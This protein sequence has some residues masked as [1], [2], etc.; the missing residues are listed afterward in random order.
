MAET[1]NL[2]NL[3]PRPSSTEIDARSISTAPAT[4]SR[5]VSSFTTDNEQQY[6]PVD[7]LPPVDGGRR[8][9]LFLIGATSIEILVWGLPFSIGILHNY[10]TNTLFK[11]YGEGT[12]TL[13]A[14][15]QTGLLYMI[16]GLFGPVITALPRWQKTMQVFGL[17]AAS[18]SMIASAFAT[19]P[20]H[21]VITIGC[22]YPL[23]GACYLPCATLLFEWFH[24]RRG[25]ASGIMYAGTGVGGTIFPFVMS[26]LINGVGYKAA[27]I[28]I[29][30]GYLILGSIALIPI[31]RRIPLS[32]YDQSSS[33]AAGG[34]R[35]RQKIDWSFMK[36]HAMLMGTLTIL[37]TSLGNFIPSLWLP[38]YADELHLSNP[39]GTALIALMNAAS[40][41][42]NALLGYLSD[43]LPLYAV[44]V[45]SC[46]G[47]AASCAFLWG[48]GKHEAELVVFVIIFGGLGLSFSALWSKIISII[49]R[50]DPVAPA[51]VFSM[52]TFVRGVGNISSGPVSD[53]LLKIS[54]LKGVTGGYGVHNYGVLLIYT[55]VTILSGGAAGLML[56]GR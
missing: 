49:S 11:G 35:R 38:S 43:R 5:P 33:G 7:V 52:F 47:S 56:R 28:S 44:V 34:V 29:G 55:A 41:P 48:F 40:V 13:A 16:A 31:Q 20:W 45:V 10:W 36:R 2:P 1:I 24:G 22:F 14:T 27:M 8:A 15:L 53:A 25:M 32:R 50:D 9:W 17:V 42:G 23:S 37:M 54:S 6:N 12:I 30:I 4:D 39:S 3:T 26:G 46:V 21:L 51:L 18:V 19:K